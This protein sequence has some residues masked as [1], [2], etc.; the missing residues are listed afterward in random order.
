MTV[1]RMYFSFPGTDQQP[2][3]E[4]GPPVCS[5]SPL[6]YAHAVP[7]PTA[8]G[9][10]HV[11][12]VAQRCREE[13]SSTIAASPTAPSAP[14][15]TSQTLVTVATVQTGGAL[16][17]PAAAHTTEGPAEAAI[18]RPLLCKAP[19]RERG[20]AGRVPR[21]P[22]AHSVTR[23]CSWPLPGCVPICSPPWADLP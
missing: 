8:T 13:P 17:Q 18:S 20:F 11:L 23:Q 19:A 4:I 16:R 9:A 1:I 5:P 7:P 15:A 14:S 10:P 6:L 12:S 21:C 3:A 2:A 22:G